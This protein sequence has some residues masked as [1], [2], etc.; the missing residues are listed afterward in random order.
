MNRPYVTGWALT[1]VL[2]LFACQP[3]NKDYSPP[4]LT[5]IHVN[6]P[7]PT[8]EELVRQYN[9]RVQLLDRLWSGAVMT[10]EWQDEDGKHHFEQGEGNFIYRQPRDV[11]LT[12]GKLGDTMFWAG[13]NHEM[14]WFI[15]KQDDG[16]AWV[17]RHLFVG[18]PCNRPLPLPIQPQ[19]IPFLFGLRP[20][21]PDSIPP[22]PAVER[23]SG[24]YL[25]EPPGLNLRMLLDP[26]TGTLVRADMYDYNGVSMITCHLSKYE[27]VEIDGLPESQWPTVATRAEIYLVG[28][29]ARMALNL[30][31][32]SDG[33]RRNRIRDKAF[34]I[35]LLLEVHDPKE[36]IF[37]DEN[38]H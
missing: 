25:I 4:P 13:S 20:L 14:Y 33:R 35:R 36:L 17:G 10:I 23:V 2:C 12:L 15:D 27:P 32:I 1:A 7:L 29:E 9:D 19:L 18:D 11:A 37:L 24:Y 16:V 30:S 34:D 22:P 31:R 38:C 21:D 5:P 26:R 28:E 6:Q 3:Q 8:Y